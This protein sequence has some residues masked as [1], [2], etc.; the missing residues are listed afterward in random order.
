MIVVMMFVRHWLEIGLP[1]AGRS[2]APPNLL[3]FILERALLS[4]RANPP[5]SCALV[6]L[7]GEGARLRRYSAR[8]YLLGLIAVAIVP[9]WIFAAYLLVSF[10]LS[11]QR[12]YHE[13]AV[14]IAT[15]SA[16]MLDDA[17]ADQSVRLD[18]LARSFDAEG[19]DF[20]RLHE[21][22]RQ[23][24]AGT[25]QVVVLRDP[26]RA[27]LFRSDVP[28]GSALPVAAA[29]PEEALEPLGSG[30]DFVSDVVVGEPGGPSVSI[31]RPMLVGEDLYILEMSVPT[32]ELHR[33][34]VGVV[35]EGWVVGVGDR[36]GVYITRSQ[37]H[38]EVTGQPGLPQYLE[39]AIG[40][41][42]TFTSA[43]Q[44]G[45]V[46]L[47]GYVRSPHTGWL[48][49]ANINLA[50]VEAPLWRSLYGVLLMAGIALA[51]SLAL[52]YALGRRFTGETAALVH[53][54]L[55]LG[56][57]RPV[58]PVESR[59]KEFALVSAAL[60]KSEA[61]LHER[62]QELEAVV[63]TAP[64]AVWFT[65]DKTAREVIRNRFAA[66]LMGLAA[67]GDQSHFGRPDQVVPTVAYKDGKEVTREDRPLSRAMRGEHTDSEEY[68]Y[69]LLSGETRNLITSARPIRDHAD[70]I[71][72]AVQISM[73][74]T[75]RKKSEEQLHLLARELNHRVKNN[76]AIVQAIAQQT[77]RHADTLET[78]RLAL[79]E[80]LA[81]LSN[82][83][84]ILTRNAWEAGSVRE[85]VET[86]VGSQAPAGQ[87]EADGPDVVLKP[88]LVM[89]L[90]LALHELGTNALKYG[91]LSVSAGTVRIT[92][93]VDEPARLLSLVW[94]ER[95]GPRVVEPGQRGF[96]SRLLERVITGERGTLSLDFEPE[97]VIAR[98][99]LQL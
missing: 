22:A 15:Q 4:I 71:V 78:A 20:A 87:V 94:Q 97:G 18:A 46:L 66:E 96:G 99:S 62:T 35:P 50:T 65:Y 91:A 74:I 84:E 63:E 58:R 70:N 12:A 75:D 69:V 56:S 10:A 59:L 21:N 2:R 90:S 17:L 34:L 44:F 14:R 25:E 29:F 93:T 64:V 23:V 57:R 42:G 48:Y 55:A 7:L 61:M 52:A 81:A 73:D 27:P 67:E 54:A 60:V 37:R 31:F 79:V 16:V 89:S 72:G 38:E 88:S 85:V 49:A 51:T 9:V 33:S 86:N 24:V 39:K 80:R 41:S 19:R 98:I 95:G 43:N 68:A 53:A 6:W 13:E 30:R 77:L 26:A 40:P 83:H 5:I 1:V 45:D 8:A 28:F 36:K 3:S 76:L 47:A 82:A 92:W 32:V 11:E